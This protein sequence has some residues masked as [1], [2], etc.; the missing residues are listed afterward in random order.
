MLC[1]FATVAAAVMLASQAA[2]RVPML[3][4]N[5]LEICV[6]S[7]ISSGAWTIAGEA[8]AAKTTFAAIFIAT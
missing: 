1:V 3:M 6:N 2:E 8:P 5:A 7:A 4:V